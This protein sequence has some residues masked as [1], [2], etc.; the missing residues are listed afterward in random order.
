MI[1][2]NYLS[3]RRLGCGVE[4]IFVTFPPL[5]L[6]VPE[7][8]L[9]MQHFRLLVRLVATLPADISS[10]KTARVGRESGACAIANV[11]S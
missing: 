7:K 6:A 2:A 5:T 1:P 3:A 4:S 9:A 11:L 10:G 8:I